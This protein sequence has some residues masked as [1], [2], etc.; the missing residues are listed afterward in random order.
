MTLAFVSGKRISLQC[1]VLAIDLGFH[2]TMI[3]DVTM[4][5]VSGKRIS[6]QLTH[7][8]HNNTTL[9]QAMVQ[10]LKC[11]NAMSAMKSQDSLHQVQIT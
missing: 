11:T 1:N 7:V 9:L 3:L 6:L 4:A 10:D 2:P 5:F 8:S